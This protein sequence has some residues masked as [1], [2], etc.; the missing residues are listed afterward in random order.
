MS[1]YLRPRVPGGTVFFTVGLAEKGSSLLVDEVARLRVA[2]RLT[3]AERP[4][5]ARAWVVLPDHMHCVWDLPEGDADYSVRWGAIKARFSRGLP[6]GHVRDSHVLR[7]EK[8]IWQRRFW[9][10]QCRGEADIAAAVR[11]CW[12]NPVRHGL[13]ERPQDW[14]YS[15]VRRD[16][17][18]QT[19]G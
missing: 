15:S 7:R 8:G 19:Q 2:V 3:M 9:E 16:D 4:F 13:V 10:H 6:E 5:R 12:V 17:P 14:P 18:N 1:S 11:F